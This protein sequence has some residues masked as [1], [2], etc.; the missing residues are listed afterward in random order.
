MKFFWLFGCAFTYKRLK[1]RNLFTT[2]VTNIW[3]IDF[4]SYNRKSGRKFKERRE[5]IIRR[6][7]K[8]IGRR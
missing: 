8:K 6:L 5:R 7:K 3:L 1:L 2:L 4:R